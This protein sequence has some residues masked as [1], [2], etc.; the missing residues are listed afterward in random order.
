[1]GEEGYRFKYANQ[2]LEFVSRAMDLSRTTNALRGIGDLARSRRPFAGRTRLKD[3]VGIKRNFTNGIRNQLRGQKSHDGK[4]LRTA[5]SDNQSSGRGGGKPI[6]DGD[7]SLNT[8][9]W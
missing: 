3:S 9:P 2:F 5:P 4:K 1:M 6:D 7:L 8:Q